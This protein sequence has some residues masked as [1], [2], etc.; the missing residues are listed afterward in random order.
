[1]QYKT[2][3]NSNPQGKPRV[4]FT[5]HPADVKLYFKNITEVVFTMRIPNIPRTRKTLSVT[6]TVC[7]LS[8]WS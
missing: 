5:G 1:M 3:G 8:F 7:S 6:S 2:R 4:Y